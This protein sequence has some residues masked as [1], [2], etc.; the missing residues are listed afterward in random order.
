MVNDLLQTTRGNL[1]GIASI[2]EVRA[3]AGARWR[4]SR[5]RWRRTSAS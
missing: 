2:D 4:R 5:R 3:A 1:A